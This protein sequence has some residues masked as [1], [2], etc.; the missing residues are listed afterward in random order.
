MVILCRNGIIYKVFNNMCNIVLYLYQILFLP[1][2]ELNWKIKAVRLEKKWSCYERKYSPKFVVIN[3][4]NFPVEQVQIDRRITHLALCT[5]RRTVRVGVGGS[6]SKG[7]AILLHVPDTINLNFI[8]LFS[9][10]AESAIIRK[11][12]GCWCV[13]PNV[14][15][16][17]S[18]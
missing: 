5:P 12:G 13:R 4:S 15:L 7:S 18:E 8:K 11:Q 16:F 10:T 6:S 1:R 9:N 14:C 3:K 17:D 2:T